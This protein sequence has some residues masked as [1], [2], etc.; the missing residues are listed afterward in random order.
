VNRARVRI[1]REFDR[2]AARRKFH[3][4]RKSSTRSKTQLAHESG[5]E[6][7][8][9]WAPPSASRWVGGCLH[10]GGSLRGAEISDSDKSHAFPETLLR[11]IQYVVR[12]YERPAARLVY[13]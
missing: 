13:R 6:W 11:T 12:N 1:N 2:R 8:F 7:R 4:K 5:W 10:D 3:Y 9:C